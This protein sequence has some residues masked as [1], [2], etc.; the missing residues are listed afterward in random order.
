MEKVEYPA[1]LVLTGKRDKCGTVDPYFVG[2]IDAVILETDDQMM[3]R[4]GALR[5]L[6]ATG[7]SPY[8]YTLASVDNAEQVLEE[9]RAEVEAEINFGSDS[10]PE[11]QSE[12]GD[13]GISPASDEPPAKSLGTDDDTTEPDPGQ[14]EAELP[15]EIAMTILYHGTGQSIIPTGPR[16]GST[17]PLVKYERDGQ[18][19]RPPDDNPARL[20]QRLYDQGYKPVYPEWQYLDR[21]SPRRRREVYRL[22]GDDGLHYETMDLDLLRQWHRENPLSTLSDDERLE[23]YR[24]KALAGETP[25]E[26]CRECPLV[27]KCPHGYGACDRKRALASER[28][29]ELDRPRSNK[30]PRYH[31]FYQ[32]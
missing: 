6:A 32:Y 10:G 2:F 25:F 3:A 8:T 28:Q 15:R 19:A 11:S 20:R 5:A 31:V 9:R 29:R 30:N 18:E 4:L 27:A 13:V 17:C 1:V 23:L 12:A 24:E 16:L 7:G 14:T 21:G 26:A 22:N